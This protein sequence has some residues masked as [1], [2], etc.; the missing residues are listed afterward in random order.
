MAAGSAGARQ[1]VT[2]PDGV[3]LARHVHHVLRQHAGHGRGQAVRQVVAVGERGGDRVRG[4]GLRLRMGRGRGR[5]GGARSRS[6]GRALGRRRRKKRSWS[7]RFPGGREPARV[8]RRVEG[9]GGGGPDRP[10]ARGPRRT[11][12]GRGV[13]DAPVTVSGTTTP[14]AT[15]T[16]ATAPDREPVPAHPERPRR[17]PV[18]AGNRWSGRCRRA[19]AWSPFLGRTAARGQGVSGD[20]VSPGSGVSG[21]RVSPGS[22]VSRDRVSRDRVSPGTGCL[23]AR[24]SQGLRYLRSEGR[25]AG[26]P[27]GRV[28]GRRTDRYGPLLGVQAAGPRRRLQVELAVPG[29]QDERRPLRLGVP[30]HGLRLQ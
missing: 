18:G 25:K 6:R 20:R 7:R 15:T 29:A 27:G 23:R 3:E 19:M 10:R 21:D 14:A 30:Q 22:G 9:R 28:T 2:D 24:V 8:V 1:I 5:G 13:A 26:R 12:S 16:V 17:H 4:P 11:R